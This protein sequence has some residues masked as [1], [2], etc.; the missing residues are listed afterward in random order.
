MD[1]IEEL[2]SEEKPQIAAVEATVQEAGNL[3]SLLG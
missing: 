2:P 3:L 1:V